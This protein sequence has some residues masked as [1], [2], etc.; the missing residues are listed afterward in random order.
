MVGSRLPEPELEEPLVTLVLVRLIRGPRPRS[1]RVLTLC[2]AVATR[3]FDLRGW[4]RLAPGPPRLSGTGGARL[5]GLMLRRPP[6]SRGF[7]RRVGS[8]ECPG[9]GRGVLQRWFG[10]GIVMVLCIRIFFCFLW[11]VLSL[12][13]SCFLFL[14]FLRSYIQIDSVLSCSHFILIQSYLIPSCLNGGDHDRW[15]C[16]E[17]GSCPS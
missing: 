7:G 9:R 2:G 17:K 14:L 6:P 10:V 3:L 12:V 4:A 13:F 16:L 11:I 5:L 15:T 1:A 8:G